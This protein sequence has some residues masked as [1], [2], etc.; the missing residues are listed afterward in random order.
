MMRARKSIVGTA[1]RPALF[2][3]AAVLVLGGCTSI[4]NAA[5]TV[6][7]GPQSIVSVRSGGSGDMKK[8]AVVIGLE[9]ASPAAPAGFG[10]HFQ[11]AI[12]E[13]LDK[14]CR[15]LLFDLD[16]AGSLKSPPKLASGVVDGYALTVLGRRQ[17]VNFF[18]FGSLNDVRFQEEKKG[19]WLWKNIRY[20]LRVAVRMEIFDVETATK[21][22]DESLSEEME[23]DEMQSQ[24]FQSAGRIQL[25]DLKPPLAAIMRKA[26]QRACTTLRDQPWRG[27]IVGGGPQKIAI[28]SGLKA[29]LTT[30]KTLEVFGAGPVIESKDG[31]RYVMPGAKIGEA[32]ISSV[33]AGDAEATLQEEGVTGPGATVRVKP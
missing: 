19:F 14:E 10:A 18:V 4:K 30:G 5:K 11:T 26:A 24:Q 7:E 1:L 31:Q 33:S 9:P 2:L 12:S 3:L 22:L 16:L 25:G 17:G 23:L 32:V 6:K 27:F 8:K 15:E 13:S 29:G 20:S 28:S 21:I